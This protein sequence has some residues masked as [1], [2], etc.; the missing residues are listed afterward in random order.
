[1]FRYYTVKSC[2]GE[3]ILQTADSAAAIDAA[4]AIGSGSQVIPSD[5]TIPL[6]LTPR[7]SGWLHPCTIGF[8]AFMVVG[9]WV[10]AS[11]PWQ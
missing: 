3:T 2:T 5:S 7:K 11:V 6:A 1:M 8:I 4:I 10:W 9:T